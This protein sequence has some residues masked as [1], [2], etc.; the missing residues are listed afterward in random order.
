[1]QY[2]LLVG[3]GVCLLLIGGTLCWRAQARSASRD[4]VVSAEEASPAPAPSTMV[5]PSAAPHQETP[6]LVPEHGLPAT[7][8]SAAE[9]TPPPSPSPTPEPVWITLGDQGEYR[10]MGHVEIPAI[11]ID[12]DLVMISW[13][14]VEQDGQFAAVWQTVNGAVGYHR[15]SAPIGGPG[16]TVL[17]GHTRGTAQGEL[18]GIGSL[19][20]GDEIRLW[21]ADG[22][23]F[24]YIVETSLTIQE[25]G[26]TLEQRQRNAQYLRDTGDTRLTLVTCWPE[27]SYTHRVIVIARPG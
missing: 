3:I 1:M 2:R 22:R 19:A 15:G 4:W 25:A 7:P 16:N 11:G 6:A 12:Q 18:E 21:D 17:S 10:Y 23:P 9:A 20:Q 14:L 5:S 24:R 8:E 13:D 26:L 27:W